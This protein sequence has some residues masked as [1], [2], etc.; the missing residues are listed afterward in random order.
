MS[1]PT[2]VVLSLNRPALDRLL[3]GDTQ[4]EI[5]LRRQVVEEFAKRRLKELMSEPTFKALAQAEA[6]ALSQEVKAVVGERLYDFRTSQYRAEV[7]EEILPIIKAVV[8]QVVRET[9]TEMVSKIVEN[10]TPGTE[11]LLLRYEHK[12]MTEANEKFQKAMDRIDK[13]L[14]ERLDEA[15][16]KRVQDEIQRR[17]DLASKGLSGNADA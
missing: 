11:R 16:E 1:E 5:E 13:G 7:R 8:E 15:F 10:H 17:F 9:V 12:L 3:G 6:L 2:T 4:L 14:D